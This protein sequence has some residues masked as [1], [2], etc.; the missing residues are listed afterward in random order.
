VKDR[1]S[2]SLSDLT[3]RID[4]ANFGALVHNERRP[5][6]PGTLFSST[7]NGSVDSP[8]QSTVRRRRTR[9]LHLRRSVR[10]AVERRQ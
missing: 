8:G 2:A 6:E 1:A 10:H 9:A 4:L 3:W 7:P 5:E